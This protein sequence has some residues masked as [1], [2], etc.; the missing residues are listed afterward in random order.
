MICKILN[1]CTKI[2]NCKKCV[3]FQSRKNALCGEGNNDANLMLIAQAPGETEDRRGKMFIGP[4]GKVLNSLLS[5]AGVSRNDIYMTNLIKC[6]LPNYRNPKQKEIN[7]CSSYLNEEI[8]RV[9]PVIISPLGYYATRYI[10]D[11]YDLQMPREKKAFKNI[12]G[13]LYFTGNIKI[14]PL[15]HPAV[16]IHNNSLK[17][18]MENNYKKL[19]VF[20]KKCKWYSSFSIKY[21]YESG[22]LDKKWITKYC[23]G[24]WENCIRYWKKKRGE[25]CSDELLP[26][27]TIDK[28]LKKVGNK[29]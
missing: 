12:I 14:Y 1:L 10:F 23:K 24:D 25:Q 9:K 11:K 5:K 21:F 19:G 16:L 20:V 29:S 13:K 4:S 2:K 28:N 7:R 26:D 27:G 18:S 22:F 17:L 8:K 15:G 3:L 6:K